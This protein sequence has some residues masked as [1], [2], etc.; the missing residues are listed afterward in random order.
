MRKTGLLGVLRNAVLFLF[1]AGFLAGEI[2]KVEDACATN[3]ADLVKLNR[4]DERRCERENTLYTNAIG[5]L[6][7]SES[8]SH[9]CTA[10]LNDYATEFLLTLFVLLFDDIG[11]SDGVTCLEVGELLRLLCQCVLS[12]FE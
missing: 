2:A 4:I 1:D 3:L 12:Y 7:D 11:N 8:L 6:A 10:T 9:T 5:Y